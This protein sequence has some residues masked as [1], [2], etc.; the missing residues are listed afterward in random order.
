MGGLIK[1]VSVITVVYR[2]PR[3]SRALDSVL[4]QQVDCEIEVVVVS[5]ET[6]DELN[7]ILDSY[8]DRITVLRNPARQGMYRARNQGLAVATGE[9]IA[10]LNADDYYAD[11]QALAAVLEVFRSDPAVE[12]VY[13]NVR[14][15]NSRGK[16]L[17]S[18]FAKEASRLNCYLGWLPP[19]PTVFYR[20]E[21]FDRVHHY[22]ERFEIDGDAELLFR[23]LMRERAPYRRLDRILTNFEN[24]GMSNWSVRQR[25]KM[26]WEY[27]LVW[28]LNDVPSVLCRLAPL[29][30]IIFWVV[31]YAE[32]ISKF[33]FARF[34]GLRN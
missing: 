30:I 20:R 24:G 12:L 7:D 3:L 32:T 5:D 17:P 1:K 10:F 33:G 4:G 28:R 13:G 34:S 6:D 18:R 15:V 11:R 21:V 27:R 14:K 2:D 26:A 8:G 29:L 22:H 31:S 23:L 19:D 9:V 25:L 16:T